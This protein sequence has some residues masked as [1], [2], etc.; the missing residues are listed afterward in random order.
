M[1]GPG[2]KPILLAWNLTLSDAAPNYNYM[3][4]PHRILVCQPSVSTVTHV[5]IQFLL[6]LG[7]YL[8]IYLSIYLRLHPYGCIS[9]SLFICLLF[10]LSSYDFFYILDLLF[11]SFYFTGNYIKDFKKTPKKSLTT[12]QQITVT[13]VSS[14]LCAQLCVE[15]TG[16]LC[17]TFT[18]CGNLTSCT[19]VGL[20]TASSASQI[21]D[22]TTCDLYT[23]T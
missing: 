2:L 11:Y 12:I 17:Q 14:V 4:G 5:S 6:I 22:N 23:S 1:L 21:Q 3:F 16:F 8:S 13:N 9:A 20:N 15:N 18:Y 19:I 7:V 10:I